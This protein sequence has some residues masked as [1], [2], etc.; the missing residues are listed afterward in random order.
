M[1]LGFRRLID[2]QIIHI[3]IVDKFFGASIIVLTYGYQA[4]I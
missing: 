2:A 4:K 1:D 3:G